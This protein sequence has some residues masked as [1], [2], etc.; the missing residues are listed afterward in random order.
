M[1][2][3]VNSP[4]VKTDY[5]WFNCCSY[6]LEQ[7]SIWCH[8]FWE[9]EEEEREG[10]KAICNHIST[11]R[12]RVI[13]TSFLCPDGRTLLLLQQEGHKFSPCRHKNKPEEE[14][15]INKMLELIKVQNVI[16]EQLPS[17]NDQAEDSSTTT[18][19]SIRPPFTWIGN[20]LRRSH[21]SAAQTGSKMRRWI[22]LDSQSFFDF[23]WNPA[24][25]ANITKIDQNWFFA[26][27]AWA[28]S[29]NAKTM[30]PGYGP[31][32]KCVQS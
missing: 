18:W 17:Q 24:L 2:L 11:T 30:L 14:W 1:F 31:E 16:S 5:Q 12:R 27:N 29:T 15:A 13:S 32:T 10:A 3:Q 8:I 21:F 22:L 4:W 20:Q 26:P 19:T 9:Q 6:C 23:F 25:V 7:S 28:L